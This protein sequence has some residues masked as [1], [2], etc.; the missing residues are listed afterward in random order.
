MVSE[1]K[2]EKIPW[3]PIVISIIL[4]SF[5]GIG[6]LFM[7]PPGATNWYSLGNLG[8][9]IAIPVSAFVSIMCAGFLMNI[10]SIREKI[11]LKVLTY[12]YAIG[13]TL[14][15]LFSDGDG[16]WRQR[17]SIIACRWLG[18]FPT[19]EYVPWFVAPRAEI[20]QQLLTGGVPV[21]WADWIPSTL[22]W[23]ILFSV[24]GMFF[25]SLGTIFRRL[26]IEVEKVP[27]PQTSY[28]YTIVRKISGPSRPLKE[29]L[30]TPFIIGIIIGVAFNVPLFFGRFFPWFPDIYG[31]RTSTCGS[32]AH[33]LDPSWPIAPIIGLAQFNKNP[34]MGAVFYF[35]PLSILFSGVLWQIIFLILMQIAYT[36]GYYTELPSMAGCGRVWCGVGYRHGEP[37]KW[38]P[39]VYIGM[40]NGLVIFYLIQNRRYITE[41]LRAALGRLSKDRRAEI[42]KNEPISYRNAY[43][44]FTVSTILM[45]VL[46]AFY[47]ISLVPAIALIVTDFLFCMVQTRVYTIAG[48]L[49]PQGTGI[50]SGHLKLVMGSGLPSPPTGEWVRVFTWNHFVGNSTLCG[51]GWPLPASLSSYQM[52][53]LTGTHPKS[54]LKIVVI[55]QILGTLVASIAIIWWLYLF[56]GSKLPGIS[57]QFY[58]WINSFAWPDAEQ[59]RPSHEPWVPHAIAGALF[60][61]IL[62][63]L[64]ARFLW[65]PLEP[66]SILMVTGRDIEGPWV[67][68]V[69]AW[70]LKKL[71]L[72]IGGSKLYEDV[73]VPTASG[74]LVG[75]LATAVLGGIALI[76][77]FFVP[78]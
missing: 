18:P 14:C 38:M 62:M 17:L 56:G 25:I 68:V 19:E 44:M 78:F 65:F 32:G 58:S 76:G 7:M 48:Y 16:F 73:G 30:G 23:W 55:T 29:R 4:M 26:L 67:M 10:K 12:S 24:G 66:I 45:I 13:L 75:Y 3:I 39:F 42:E 22:F 54:V 61:I 70:I 50:S 5:V 27:F 37:F 6:W 71:T 64:H 60:A 51:W 43:L 77:R 47:G 21:P 74:F 11:D 69:A 72:Q 63:Y 35:A 2:L 53:S 52:A 28:M 34:A 36:M 57:G 41:T 1:V 15:N 31:W 9:M 33:Q 49:V 46:W 59:Y 8:C 20:A 40:A